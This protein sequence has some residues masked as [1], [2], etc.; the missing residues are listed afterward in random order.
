V[1]G[2]TLAGAIGDGSGHQGVIAGAGALLGASVGN[3][4]ARSRRQAGDYYVVEQ[5]CT[6]E[7]ERHERE[8]VTGYRVSYQYDGNIYHTTTRRDPGDTI[9]LRMS[10]EPLR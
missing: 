10:L 9:T 5:R 3:D 6:T 4:I 1:L 2:G 8:E 7:Y